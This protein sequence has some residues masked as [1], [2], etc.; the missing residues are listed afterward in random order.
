MV[1]VTDKKKFWVRMVYEREM[2]LLHL[3]SLS[4]WIHIFRVV[5]EARRRRP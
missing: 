1:F 3:K 5:Q 2:W 4:R